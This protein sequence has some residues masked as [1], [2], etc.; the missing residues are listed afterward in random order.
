MA[1]LGSLLG[2]N[3]PFSCVRGMQLSV[4]PVLA[5]STL[6]L[7]SSGGSSSTS[8]SGSG[9]TPAVTLASQRPQ[10]CAARC[11]ANPLCDAFFVAGAR[12]VLQS[13]PAAPTVQM[14]ANASVAVSCLRYGLDF[15]S[16]GKAAAQH[17]LAAS[18]AA[19]RSY[20][21]LLAGTQ[22]ALALQSQRTVSGVCTAAECAELCARSGS[23][24][25]GDAPAAL[26]CT[27]VLHSAATCQCQLGQQPLAAAA[28]ALLSSPPSSGAAAPLACVQ[29]D[30][31]FLRL[32]ALNDPSVVQFSLGGAR[33]I[34]HPE[35]LGYDDAGEVCA[36][37]HGGGVL[38]SVASLRGALALAAKVLRALP[39]RLVVPAAGAAPGLHGAWVG[40]A[41]SGAALQ[42]VMRAG[43][44]AADLEWQD[45]VAVNGTLLQVRGG[46]EEWQGGRQPREG[47]N[48]ASAASGRS[49]RRRVA[50]S[51]RQP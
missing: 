2:G 4:G 17:A 21:C 9:A 11:R 42:A 18:P 40:L 8:S 32:G 43:G 24:G 36:R 38:A 6:L 49:G 41:G 29:E 47:Q 44:E 14:A 22:Q 7:E 34:Y 5:T 46:R 25:A 39:P 50:G 33:L 30:R 19:A 13:R 15:V 12:C 28:P 16:A 31:D 10:L 45:G 48:P 37:Q 20:K 27:A 3:R 26:R 23:G 1:S 35:P 51:V